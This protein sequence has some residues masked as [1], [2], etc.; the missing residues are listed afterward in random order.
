VV[1]EDAM[2]TGESHHAALIARLDAVCRRQE[3]LHAGLQ[4]MVEAVKTQRESIEV[5]AAVLEAHLREC[6]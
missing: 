3:T 6:E 4:A 5:L 1:R 2:D